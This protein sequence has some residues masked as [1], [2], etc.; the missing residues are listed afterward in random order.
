MWYKWVLEGEGGD[1]LAS[2]TIPL[3]VVLMF[4]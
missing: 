2:V 4:E 1:E 3:P